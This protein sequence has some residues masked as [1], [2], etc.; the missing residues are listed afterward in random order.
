[1]NLISPT[2]YPDYLE[3]DTLIVLLVLIIVNCLI[4]CTHEY[5]CFQ[6]DIT[7]I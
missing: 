7:N 2:E 1:M 6:H 5:S 4:L 3:L